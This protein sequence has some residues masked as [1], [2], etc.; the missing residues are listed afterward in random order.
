M[1]HGKPD[2]IGAVF[3]QRGQKVG[4]QY[5]I[6]GDGQIKLD[7]KVGTIAKDLASESAKKESP[8]IAT[9]QNHESNKGWL[10]SGHHRRYVVFCRILGVEGMTVEKLAGAQQALMNVCSETQNNPALQVSEVHSSVYGRFLCF[11]HSVPALNTAC[12]VLDQAAS[13]GVRLSIGIDAGRLETV[14]DLGAKN[15]IGAPINLAARLAARENAEGAITLTPDVYSAAIQHEGFTKDCFEGPWD[16]KVKRTGFQYYLLKHTAPNI[17]R[18]VPLADSC[19]DAAHVVVYDIAGFSGKNPDEQWQAVTKLRRPIISILVN[20]GADARIKNQQLWY[21]PGGDGG[22]LVF[23]PENGGDEAAWLFARELVR[24]CREGVEIRV[25][26][27]TGSVVVIEDQL[28]VGSAVLLA[29]KL[30]GYPPSW[31]I[32]VN[33]PFWSGLA[34]ARSGWQAVAVKGKEA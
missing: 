8:T 7:A 26:I 32:C 15:V 25:G 2:P 23:A 33:R 30:C 34:S 21:A 1:N 19:Q 29:D 4:T 13:Q 27:A 22:V 6:A 17:G 24:L 3:D 10:A 14:D 9:A 18:L 11:P 16:G 5:N 31:G 12:R 20:L 28:P